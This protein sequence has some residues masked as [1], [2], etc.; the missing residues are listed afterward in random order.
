MRARL[1]MA[2]LGHAYVDESGVGGETGR[3]VLSGLVARPEAWCRL[4]DAWQKELDDMP[5]VRRWHMVKA[6][7]LSDEYSAYTREQVGA[8]LERLVDLIAGHVVC[9]A[10]VSIVPEDYM[11]LVRGRVDYS[12]WSN[13]KK[14]DHAFSLLVAG[15]LRLLCDVCSDHAISA[16]DLTFDWQQEHRRSV[17]DIIEDFREK[18]FTDKERNFLGRIDMPKQRDLHTYVPLQAADVYVWHQHRART[19]QGGKA[20]PAY[21]KMCTAIGHH[22][23]VLNEGFLRKFIVYADCMGLLRDDTE[24]SSSP[25]S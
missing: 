6:N 7:M 23:A 24:G 19:T 10:T 12:G 8:K 22:A 15:L 2:M 17:E 11:K 14:V 1:G 18:C 9:G 5:G 21:K 16:L 20:L 13:G 3:M 4:A 25:R